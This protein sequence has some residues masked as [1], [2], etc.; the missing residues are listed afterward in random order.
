[1]LPPKRERS[2]SGCHKPNRRSLIRIAP[3]RGLDVGRE[4]A[5]EQG[6][7]TGGIKNHHTKGCAGES[8]AITAMADHY[9]VGVDY[10]L[11]VDLAAMAD[12]VNVNE[13]S[14][15]QLSHLLWQQ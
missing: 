9:P 10:R 7:T 8:L 5:R 6:K 11:I 12:S 2:T 14:D 4:L 1:M 3:L 15:L 13:V